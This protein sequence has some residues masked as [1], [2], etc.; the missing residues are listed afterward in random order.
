MPLLIIGI[1][2]FASY[3]IN[4]MLIYFIYLCRN[5]IK[6]LDKIYQKQTGQKLKH[7]GKYILWRG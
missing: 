1:P 2:K 6:Q 7:M 4:V 5:F 3:H